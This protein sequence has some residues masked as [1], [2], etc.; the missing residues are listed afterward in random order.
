[1]PGTEAVLNTGLFNIILIMMITS[2]KLVANKGALHTWVASSLTS[3]A[4]SR[5]I[6]SGDSFEFLQ[7]PRVQLEATGACDGVQEVWA[8]RDPVWWP[9]VRAATSL[10]E[11]LVLS[12]VLSQRG[13]KC[14]LSACGGADT[15]THTHSSPTRALPGRS[16]K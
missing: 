6:A 16:S 11:T 7:P 8:S 9:D 5:G 3:L 2:R 12:Q 14:A 1:M 10:G 4:P 15:Q 13:D